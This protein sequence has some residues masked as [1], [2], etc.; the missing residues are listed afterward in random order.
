[1]AE[2]QKRL[3]LAN[4]ESYTSQITDSFPNEGLHDLGHVI[5]LQERKITRMSYRQLAG[6]MLVAL[7][8]I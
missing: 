7:Q 2:P 4:G 6:Q 8:G 5:A 1:M 3:I